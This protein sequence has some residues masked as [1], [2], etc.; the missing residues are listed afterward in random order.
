MIDLDDEQEYLL[1]VNLTHAEQM[2]QFGWCM[3]D[4]GGHM[5]E[6]CPQ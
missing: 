5:S 3:C 6:G 1:R 2:E 4:G